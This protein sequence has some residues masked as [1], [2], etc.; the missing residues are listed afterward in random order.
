FEIDKPVMSNDGAAAGC[1][2]HREAAE[3]PIEQ[4]P[5]VGAS[6]TPARQTAADLSGLH[7]KMRQVGRDQVEPAPGDGLPHV[8]AVKFD[9]VAI[10]EFAKK[11]RTREGRFTLDIDAAQRGSPQRAES[12]EHDTTAAPDFE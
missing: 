5:P 7:R 9:I 8:A 11:Q 10:P 1:K 6:G 12:R 4:H 2:V 3:E